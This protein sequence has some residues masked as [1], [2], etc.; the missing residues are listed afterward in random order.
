MRVISHTASNTE[1]VCALG[2]GNLLVGVDA[3]SD[4]PAD[5]VRQ[6]PKLGRDLQLD[7]AAVEALRPDLVLTSLTVPGHERIVAALNRR[8]I[9]TLVAD[10]ISLEDVFDDV[11]RIAK[12]LGVPVAGEQLAAEMDAAMPQRVGARRTRVLVEWWPKPVIVPGRDSWV[13]GLLARLGAHNPWHDAPSKSQPVTPEQVVSAGPDLVITSWCGV[14]E[15]QL[16][17][18]H[19]IKRDGWQSVPA[20]TGGA[21]T[22]SVKPIW[23]GPARVWW[24]ATASL[25]STSTPCPTDL[26]PTGVSAALMSDAGHTPNTG[27]LISYQAFGE[28]FIRYLITVPRLKGEVEETL[29]RTVEGSRSAL[30]K[31]LLVASYQFNPNDVQ[32]RRRE[33]EAS[34]V[35]FT[36]TLTG[37]LDITLRLMGLPVRTPMDIEINVHIDV[38]TRHPLTI[39]L[40]PQRVGNRDI[41]VT[42]RLPRE[43]RALPTHLL[44]RINPLVMTVRESI[45]REVNAQLS[46]DDVHAATTID[47]L[48][49]A[50]GK[51]D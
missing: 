31:D 38:E 47:V 37:L 1:I 44:N 20:V 10:P 40:V 32:V 23:G 14:P 50:E 30:P 18:A 39:Q 4:F 51:L 36:L 19:V 24:R 15:H 43:L 16:R 11:R 8:G 22:P 2:A 21:C 33:G 9:P 29:R 41:K 26:E 42:A 34:E 7:L 12:A 17:P 13:T 25:R 46:R 3:D 45:V 6:I 35:A 5:I 49:L 48:K 27:D 28:N